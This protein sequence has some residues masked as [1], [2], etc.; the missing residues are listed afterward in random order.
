ML[1]NCFPSHVYLKIKPA[2]FGSVAKAFKDYCPSSLQLDTR[3][4]GDKN[5]SNWISLRAALIE[6]PDDEKKWEEAYT[7]AIGTTPDYFSWI[8]HV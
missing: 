3:I 8:I 4:A 6:H 7:G 2:F 5:V 1:L